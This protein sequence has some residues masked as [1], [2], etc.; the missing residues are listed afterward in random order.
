M[1]VWFVLSEM[2]ECYPGSYEPPEPP[3]D[4]CICLI[5]VAETRSRAKYLAVKGE[6]ALL[7][8]RP[9]DWPLFAV[10]RIGDAEGPARVLDS[11]AAD[12]WWPKCPDIQNPARG[13]K[14]FNAR[15]VAILGG[16]NLCD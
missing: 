11:G 6:R 16:S 13:P 9:V 15:D 10:R 2:Y 8:Y 5:V 12:P 4:G 7:Q 14:P 1:R 3:E